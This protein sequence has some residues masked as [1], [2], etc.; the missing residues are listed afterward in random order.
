MIHKGIKLGELVADAVRKLISGIS[1]FLGRA[2]NTAGDL[3]LGF[4]K[5]VLGLLFGFIAT[6]ARRAIDSIR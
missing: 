3:T 4:L 1:H 5:Y 6:I 2:I